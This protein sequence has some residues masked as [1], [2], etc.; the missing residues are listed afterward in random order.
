MREENILIVEDEVV[1]SMMLEE[2]LRNL[3]FKNIQ[4]AHTYMDAEAKLKG[5][6]FDLIL[7]DI[8]LGSNR[9]GVDLASSILI[10][11]EQTP[12]IFITGNSDFTTV[13]RAKY[14]NPSNFITKPVEENDLMIKIE[15]ALHQRKVNPSSS[16]DDAL[17]KNSA[18][19]ILT[20]RQIEVL[21]LII[22]GESNKMIAE[23]LKLS[24]RTVDGHRNNI[25]N[26]MN[27]KNTADLVRIAVGL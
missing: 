9:D 21:K 14:A 15:L 3:S 7:M 6:F 13:T 17:K 5:N 4:I 19:S 26:A 22:L 2:M 12:L 8:N 10:T 1:I 18:V 11:Q 25:M 27:A 16:L 24:A 20:E 23:K